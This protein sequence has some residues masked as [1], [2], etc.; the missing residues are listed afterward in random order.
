[1][2]IKIKQT[3]RD[4][5]QLWTDCEFSKGGVYIFGNVVFDNRRG[6]Y[7]VFHN[8]HNGRLI[9]YGATLD[10]CL[11]VIERSLRYGSYYNVDAPV[12]HF[13]C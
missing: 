11:Q 13:Y 5:Y 9:G 3:G 1:M 2:D 8:G 4:Q 7:A 10:L 12:F 6:E